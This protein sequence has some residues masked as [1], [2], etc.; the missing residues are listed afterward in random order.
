M[1]STVIPTLRYRDPRQMIDWLCEVVGFARHAVYEDEKGGIA[2]AELSLGPGLIMIGTAR[3]DAFGKLQQLPAALGG[4]SQSPYVVVLDADAVHRRAVAGGATIVVAL[5][6][7]SF[8][9]RGFSF[10][11]PE[12]HLWTVG[13]YDPWRAGN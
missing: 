9:G 1:T 4:N 3:D 2:H 10:R 11:D 13:T 6:D 5:K 7:E 12:G 8:G